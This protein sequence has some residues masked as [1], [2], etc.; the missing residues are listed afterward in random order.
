MG[1]VQ[2]LKKL[3]NTLHSYFKCCIP[4]CINNFVSYE[5]LFNKRTK[6]IN[7]IGKKISLAHET[8][9]FN[10]HKQWM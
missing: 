7:H 1:Y 6:K 10:A 9:P 3:V 5:I 2:S 4:V 8:Q